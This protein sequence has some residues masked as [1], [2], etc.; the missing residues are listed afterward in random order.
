MNQ[1]T[2]FL[3]FFLLSACLKAEQAQTTKE[4]PAQ[5]SSGFETEDSFIDLNEAVRSR[6]YVRRAVISSV[7]KSTSGFAFGRP[8]INHLMGYNAVFQRATGEFTKYQTGMLGLSVGYIYDNG[9][10]AEGGLEFSALSDAYIGLRYV[11]KPENF[12]LWPFLGLGIGAEVN[13]LKFADAPAEARNYTGPNKMGF[14]TLGFLVPV[15]DVGI[16]AEVRGLFYGLS[17]L[18]FTTG[19]GVILFL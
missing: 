14:F 8:Y 4:K 1:K 2:I 12:S 10:A 3:I 16:K 15:V 17:R 13:L 5:D 6:Q 18:A 9:L 19:I 7:V 11:Y